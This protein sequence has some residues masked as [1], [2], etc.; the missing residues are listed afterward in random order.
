[1]QAG[2]RCAIDITGVDKQQINRG[3]WLHAPEIAHTGDRIDVI[4]EILPGV[5]FTLKHLLPVKLYI[6]AK[7]LPAKLY[8]LERPNNGNKLVAG[9]KVLVQLIFQGA[10]ACCRVAASCCEMTESR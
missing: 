4:L 1:M 10:V 3:D 9:S 2:Q 7:R 5:P 8:L 6:G